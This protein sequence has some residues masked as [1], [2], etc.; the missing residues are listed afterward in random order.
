MTTHPSPQGFRLCALLVGDLAPS[1]TGCPSNIDQYTK[2]SPKWAT[3]GSPQLDV[4]SLGNGQYDGPRLG[5]HVG[6]AA[7]LSGL[8]LCLP[9]PRDWWN[10]RRSTW[11]PWR[12]GSGGVSAPYCCP[13]VVRVTAACLTHA[14]LARWPPSL[15]GQHGLED[16][17]KMGGSASNLYLVAVVPRTSGY[18]PRTVPGLYGCFPPFRLRRSGI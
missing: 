15:H 16:G 13:G 2:S 9:W 7:L 8:M 6:R 11:Q 17:W 4:G 14:P 10:R 5:P 12:A 1:F 3:V 18:H